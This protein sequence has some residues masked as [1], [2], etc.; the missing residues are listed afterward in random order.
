M[1]NVQTVA[2]EGGLRTVSPEETY[3]AYQHLISPISGIID[4]LSSISKSPHSRSYV[5]QFSLGRAGD[6]Y[7]RR[8]RG[9]SSGKGRTDAQSKASCLGEAIERHSGIFRG[10]EVCQKRS[11]RSFQG[12]AIHPETC[13]LF[14]ETQYRERKQWNQQ[15]KI[16]HRV[17]RP[18]DE[19]EEIAWSPVWSFTENRWKWIPTAYGYYSYPFGDQEPFCVGDSNGCAAGNTKEEAILQGLFELIERDSVAIW[20][21]NKLHRPNV[22]LDA[23]EDPYLD[24]LKGYYSAMNREMWVLDLTFDLAIPVF[25]AIAWLKEGGD[26]EISMGFG[27]HIDPK[28]ALFRAITELNLSLDSQ[29]SAKVHLKEH[30]YLAP[31]SMQ[32]Y[33]NS[34]KNWDS[35]RAKVSRLDDRNQNPNF[36]GCLGI[37]PNGTPKRSL[38][39]LIVHCQNILE[40][41]GM[42]LLV[43]DQTRPDIGMPVVKVVVPG[44]RH[45]WHRLAPGRLY[46]VPVAVSIF[47]KCLQE[48]ELNKIPMFG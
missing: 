33:P 17:P 29:R 7:F 13:L 45:H 15:C 2:E 38:K 26:E 3:G 4:S 11:F 35:N 18:F 34:L 22:D 19:E 37:L 40:Q 46:T 8:F 21:Y 42:E 39:E 44:L 9:D 5:A 12:E 43:L 23:I 14:S 20:W 28:I 32:R 41:K 47:S 31:H 30:L 36:S 25:V 6:R 24:S 48:E 27:A 10:E 16:T 1:S